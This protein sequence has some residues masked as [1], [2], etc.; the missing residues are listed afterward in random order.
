[1]DLLNDDIEFPSLV[2][3]GF[4]D[5]D[6]LDEDEPIKQVKMNVLPMAPIRS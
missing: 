3:K 4:P 1:M 5:F 2:D 6:F